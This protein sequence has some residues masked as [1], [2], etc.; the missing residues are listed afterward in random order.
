M[1]AEEE[2]RMREDW[3]GAWILLAWLTAGK[4]ASWRCAFIGN[5]ASWDEINA[6]S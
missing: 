1:N 3:P 6:G 2:W 5:A 4:D